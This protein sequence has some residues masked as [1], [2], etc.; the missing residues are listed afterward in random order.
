METEHT[1]GVVDKALA[2]VKHTLGIPPV[3]QTPEVV[4]KPEYTDTAPVPTIEG[5]MRLDPYAYTT[6]SVAEV[7]VERARRELSDTAFEEHTKAAAQ[8]DRTRDSAKKPSTKYRTF[9]AA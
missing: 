1:E 7:N 5:A 6:K 8:I 2:F 3:D 4:A 9:L